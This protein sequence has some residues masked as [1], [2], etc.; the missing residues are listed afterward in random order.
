MRLNI[1]QEGSLKR[2][3]CRIYDSGE[4]IHSQFVVDGIDIKNQLKDEYKISI[5]NLTLYDILYLRLKY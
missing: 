2:G 3:L 5:E 1:I 4:L